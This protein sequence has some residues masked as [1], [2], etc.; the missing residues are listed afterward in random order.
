MTHKTA[1]SDRLQQVMTESR[2]IVPGAQALLGFQF[3]TV[4]TTA[5]DRLP[6]GVKVIHVAGMCA[7]ALA[8]VLL[9][10]PASFHRIAENGE[11]S[12]RVVAVASRFVLLSLVPLAVGVALD[13]WVVVLQ[14]GMSS[15]LGLLFPVATLAVAIAVWFV[16]PLVRRRQRPSSADGRE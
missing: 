11:D 10:A 14:T 12:E 6:P 16:Y 1:L 9:I 13:V 5:F 3:S 4:F 8:A 2:M 7:I 15:G